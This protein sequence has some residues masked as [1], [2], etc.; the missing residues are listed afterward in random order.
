MAGPTPEGGGHALGRGSLP[1][2]I[3]GDL[4]CPYTQQAFPELMTLLERHADRMH[5][6][7]RSFPLEYGLAPGLHPAGPALAE[8]AEEAADQGA[9]WQY[10]AEALLGGHS[11]PAAAAAAA[12]LDAGKVAAALE[13][14]SHRER[15][16]AA[17]DHGAARGVDQTPTFFLDGERLESPLALAA[18]LAVEKALKDGAPHQAR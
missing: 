2:E 1:L 7:W 9:F 13:A 5:L 4:D 10:L 16:R 14:G 6:V 3:Y 18:K 12:G 11:D 15:V 8:V 17:Y